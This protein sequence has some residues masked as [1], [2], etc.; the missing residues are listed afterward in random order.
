MCFVDNFSSF[1]V[2]GSIWYVDSLGPKICCFLDNLA[3]TYF[4]LLPFILRTIFLK[5]SKSQTIGFLSRGVGSFVEIFCPWGLLIPDKVTKVF[6][7]LLHSS[8]WKPWS[9]CH[10]IRCFLLIMWK[11][12]FKS[13]LWWKTGNEV[14]LGSV[15]QLNVLKNKCFKL[16]FLQ[17]LAE[18]VFILKNLLV[19]HKS[20][21]LVGAEYGSSKQRFLMVGSK[22]CQRIVN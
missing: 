17:S 14:E 4:T 18:R 21:L 15:R 16:F 5:R 9:R 10:I 1:S 11:L 12:I 19:N 3:E 8:F 6:Q 20:L 13:I 2:R 7:S 22:L